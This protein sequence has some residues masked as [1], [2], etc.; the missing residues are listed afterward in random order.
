M[1][2]GQIQTS[3]RSQC[4]RARCR[5]R[6]AL[7]Q[8]ISGLG[9]LYRV[10]D[11][12]DPAF[13]I[14][15]RTGSGKTALLQQIRA[16]SAQVS[17][18]DPEEL[19]MQYLHNSVLRTISSW[20]VKLDIFYKYLW[21]HVCILELIRMRYGDADDVPSRIQQLFPISDIF[22]TDKKRARQVS[23]DYLRDYG[24]DY[25]V[26]TD[27]RIKKI[28]KEFEEK[29]T[30]DARLRAA[31]GNASASVEADSSNRTMSHVETEVQDRAQSIV[32]DFQV[33]ALNS[34]VDALEKYGFDDPQK[35]YFIL[36]DDLDKD[37][38][39]DD[40]LYLDLIKSLLSTVNELNRRLRAV[41][42]I[43]ALSGRKMISCA[44]W[45]T[46]W[47]RSSKP[48]TPLTYRLLSF[49]SPKKS[50][51]AE[52]GL[53]Y[54]ISRTFMR[55][56]D[57]IDFVNKCLAE[58]TDGVTRISWSRLTGAEIGY[59]E[60]RLK[61]VIDEWRDSYFGLPALL[62]ILRRCGPRFSM[63]DISDDEVYTVLGGDRASSCAW[64]QEPGVRLLK[65]NDPIVEIKKE[66]VKA[67]YLVGLI[68]IRPPHSHRTACS[69][70]KAI[71]PSQDLEDPGLSLVVHR[72]LHSALGL[73][74]AE[75]VV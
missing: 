32:S 21:R 16:S 47:Q 33:S 72:M 48:S 73:R 59:S 34:V 50:S 57:V 63:Q 27:T 15:G 56:R 61:A 49:C 37:W 30:A 43:T 8:S 23:Q 44:W 5:D 39:P 18:L 74:E 51:H 14:V 52:D 9:Y 28:T 41:K 12:D 22:K 13:L 67:L 45:T 6:P 54:M 62:P 58:T 64:L 66:F 69:F 2:D 20:G 75:P 55:P 1:H 19:S 46:G 42:I 25:R 71:A 65:N 11:T 68:G 38:M 40:A 36:I 29:F 70:E 24:E 7:E 60:A 3:Q 35:S 10:T 17:T 4:G 26:R 31:L 53:K